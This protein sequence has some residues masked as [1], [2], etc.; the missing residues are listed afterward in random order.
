MKIVVLGSTLY[1][2]VLA[3]LLSEYGNNVIWCDYD[4]IED[5]DVSQRAIKQ[6]NSGRL[7]LSENLDNCVIMDAIFLCYSP[8]QLALAKDRLLNCSNIRIPNHTVMINGSTFG[9]H[10]TEQLKALV[11][12]SEW[13][14]L[15]DIIQEGNA[16]NSFLM[17]NKVMVGIES[18]KSKRFMLELLR[19][20]FYRP[21]HY[22]FMPILDAEFA[23]LSISGMLATRISYM[24]DIAMMAEKLGVDVMNVKHGM[25]ADNR[26]GPSYLSAGVGFG[27]ELFSHD[28]LTLSNEVSK[29]GIKSRLLEQVWQINEDQKEILFRKLWN[30]YQSDIA[31]KTVA[32]WGAAFKENTSNINNSPVHALLKA[33]WAQGVQVRLHDPD[34]LSEMKELYGERADLRYCVDQYEAIQGADALCIVTAWRQY[35]S[36]DYSRLL[37]AMTVPL[38]LDG[39]NIYDPA[40]VKSLGFIY[41]GIGRS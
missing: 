36:P 11:A 20:L 23:K 15:P 41:E 3:V 2:S 7:V 37:G 18:E 28:I 17:A 24:N 26:I 10:G 29:K 34:A 27:G 5:Y 30:Y 35:F 6:Q 13:V 21:E 25:G 16:I 39:R 40:H 4:D 38:L 31:G 32:I 33:L 22:L 14:Y 19:P 12:D 8:S 1:A 9:L